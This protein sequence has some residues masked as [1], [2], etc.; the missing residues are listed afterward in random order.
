MENMVKELIEFREQMGVSLSL[1]KARYIFGK[2]NVGRLDDEVLRKLTQKEVR[3]LIVERKVAYFTEYYES[4]L[5]FKWVK[6]VGISG[7]VAAGFAKEDEDIDVFIVVRDGCLWLYRGILTL[8][9]LFNGLFR[10]EGHG[11]DVRDKFCLNFIVEERGL[12]FVSDVF[13]FHELMFL[14]PVFNEKY[15]NY[16]FSRNGWLRDEYMVKKELLV[17]RVWKGSRVNWFVR[18][19]NFLSFPVQ[20]VYMFVSGHGPNLKRLRDN[21]RKGR[22]EFF[23]EGYK[24]GVLRRV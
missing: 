18:F 13:N 16:I 19:L 4:L 20:V 11:D 12:E 1:G 15:L 5:V 21:T 2:R 17:C 9:G 7:S 10:R 23:P 14:V 24:E 8:R 6:F 3:N 22:I